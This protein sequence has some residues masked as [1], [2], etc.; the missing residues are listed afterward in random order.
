[1]AIETLFASASLSFDRR[2]ALLAALLPAGAFAACS[3][4]QAT[5]TIAAILGAIQATCGFATTTQNIA[6]VIATVIA[7]FS[8]T[9]GA[10]TQVAVAV[11]TQ[12]ENQICAAVMA[13]AQPAAE[14]RA[15]A[16]GSTLTVIVNGV[17]VTG[18]VV[19]K[20]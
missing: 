11:A 19:P 14:P 10:A 4:A 8:A 3:T 6:D 16:P 1:M 12:I 20:S 13:A 9:A 7:G 5:T 18:T 2:K 17:Q 15:L